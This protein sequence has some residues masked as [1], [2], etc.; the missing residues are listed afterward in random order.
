MP[1]PMAGEERFFPTTFP[2]ERTDPLARMQSGG[3]WQTTIRR[4]PHRSDSPFQSTEA[5]QRHPLIRPSQKRIGDVAESPTN[6]T[7]DARRR[8]PLVRRSG[9]RL[10]FRPEHVSRAR[11]R[12][13]HSKGIVLQIP[14]CLGDCLR[15]R[16]GESLH[17][18]SLLLDAQTSLEDGYH[19]WQVQKHPA[20]LRRTD[21]PWLPLSVSR[22]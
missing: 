7:S 6:R 1:P 17:L 15:L 12:Q 16:G 21:W 3:S 4:P 13:S 14:S 10:H 11:A 18:R 9:K 22:L 8:F 20:M 19:R 5:E 2:C